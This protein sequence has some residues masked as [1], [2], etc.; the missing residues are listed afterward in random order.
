MEWH[1]TGSQTNLGRPRAPTVLPPAEHFFKW[2][3]SR[4][5]CVLSKRVLYSLHPA[6]RVGVQTQAGGAGEGWAPPLGRGH[7]SRGLGMLSPLSLAVLGLPR[8]DWWVQLSWGWAGVGCAEGGSSGQRGRG[9]A[10]MGLEPSIFLQVVRLPQGTATLDQGLFPLSPLL[11]P[12][13]FMASPQ[14]L[15]GHLHKGPSS[16]TFFPYLPPPGP[17]EL[18]CHCSNLPGCRHCQGCTHVILS[19]PKAPPA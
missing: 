14:G 17:H 5:R 12:W 1:G 19:I 18:Y 6:V 15:Q 2:R 13:C 7:W 9:V 4:A 3:L 16:L 8:A 11:T 10:R